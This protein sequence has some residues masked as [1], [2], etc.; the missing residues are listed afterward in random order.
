MG[1]Q[2]IV[3]MSS[4][5]WAGASDGASILARPYGQHEVR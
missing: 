1:N 5:G 4:V 2:S 3:E